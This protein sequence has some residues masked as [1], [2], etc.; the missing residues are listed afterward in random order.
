MKTGERLPI[1][2]R[3]PA[4]AKPASVFCFRSAPWSGPANAA[5]SEPVAALASPPGPIQNGVKPRI[6]EIDKPP[7]TK[8]GTGILTANKRQ[9][10][11]ISEHMPINRNNPS[12]HASL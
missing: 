1:T 2:G 8:L 10:T 4:K 7:G 9:V 3:R 6:I 12:D 11:L 5:F